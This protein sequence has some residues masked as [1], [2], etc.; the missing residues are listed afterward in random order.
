MLYSYLLTRSEFKIET[1]P[2]TT[3]RDRRNGYNVYVDLLLLLL[4]LSGYPAKGQD[5]QSP[6]A[7]LVKG[8]K[9]STSKT[10]RS[11]SQNEEIRS[12]ISTCGDRLDKFDG[13]LPSLVDAIQKSSAYRDFSKIK[14]SQISDEVEMWRTVLRT[15]VSKDPALTEAF[16][17][18]PDFT[19]KG[20]ESGF[21][22]LDDTLANYSDTR[23][24]LHDARRDL[25]T[26]LD[27]AYELYHS[28]LWLIVELTRMSEQRIEAAKD[29]FLASD[30]DRNP[31]T[32][33]AD[34]ALAIAIKEN[35]DMNAYLKE[36]PISWENDVILIRDLLDRIQQSDIYRE[37]M[38]APTTTFADDCEV[39]RRLMKNVILVN[40]DLIEALEAKSIYWNDDLSVMGTFVLK[41]IKQ[42]SRKGAATG[43]LPQYKDDEDA[44]FGA[45][46]FGMTVEH[47]EEYRALIDQ[48]INAAR[49]DTE[50]LALMDIVILLTAL[51]EII[52]FP[53]IPLAVSVNEYVEIAHWYSSPRSGSFINGLLAA[54]TTALREEGKLMK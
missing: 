53:S 28:L 34:N 7:P 26:S 14:D 1:A 41:T 52:N 11:L 25:T 19:T 45:T 31:S 12:L 16:R 24:L 35:P 6:V 38:A 15:I 9:L 4:E 18:N 13:I 50:R 49:W 29:K 32:R 48:Y 36:H 54:A 40:E 43:L 5:R 51:T 22:M 47:R 23:S 17:L 44:S 42:F 39:W 30:E 37:Y 3:S 27:K 33:F 10:A 8:T 2:E 21:K 46:L 20:Y